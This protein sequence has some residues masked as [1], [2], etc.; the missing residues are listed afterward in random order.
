MCTVTNSGVVCLPSAAR[1]MYVAQVCKWLLLVPK[2]FKA[3][4]VNLTVVELTSCL[5]AA[6]ILA[7]GKPQQGQQSLISQYANVKVC[8]QL[9]IIW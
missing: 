5:N 8:V 9:K 4:G 3:R 6:W 2:L 7:N 1:L